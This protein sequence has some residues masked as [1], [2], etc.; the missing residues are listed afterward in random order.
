MH[1]PISLTWDGNPLVVLPEALHLGLQHLLVLLL[2]KDIGTQ[3]NKS[4]RSDRCGR[5]GRG[6][7]ASRMP[8]QAVAKSA[9]D[10]HSSSVDS[11]VSERTER[12]RFRLKLLIRTEEQQ[13]SGTADF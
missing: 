8:R 1:I 4:R 13:N 3:Q 6:A 11:V 9:M 5:N 7:T 12:K 2:L 10:C